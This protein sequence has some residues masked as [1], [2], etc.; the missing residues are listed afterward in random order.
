MDGSYVSKLG[1]IVKDNATDII[2]KCTP[3][4]RDGL[5]FVEQSLRARPTVHPVLLKDLLQDLCPN[6]GVRRAL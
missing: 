2:C 6:F 1:N 5:P 3:C 4:Y